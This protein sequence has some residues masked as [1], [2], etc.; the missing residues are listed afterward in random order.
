M[1]PLLSNFSGDVL[2]KYL[3]IAVA[4]LLMAA[5]SAAAQ[6]TPTYSQVSAGLES[7][8]VGTDNR[9]DCW[10]NVPDDKPVGGTWRQVAASQHTCAIRT[11]G[12]VACWGVNNAGEGNP[13]PGKFTEISVGA[14]HTC[15]MR[16]DTALVCWGSQAEGQRN[17]VPGQYV[18][19]SAGAYHTCALRDDSEV[20]CWGVGVS[21]DNSG[22]PGCDQPVCPT[23][24]SLPAGKYKSVSAGSDFQCAIKAD[25]TLACAGR[26][27]GKG[28]LNPP[29]GTFT[30]V[31]AG[32]EGACAIRTD[33]TVACWGD[34][35]AEEE[36]QPP[37]G[38][39]FK[40][41]SHSGGITCGITTA[42]AVRCWGTDQYR[43]NQGPDYTKPVIDRLTAKPTKFRASRGT[44]LWGGSKKYGTV[45]R[46]ELSEYVNYTLVVRKK[47]GAKVTGS[48]T[49]F[50]APSGNTPG[51][52][53]V[54]WTGR[55][56]VGSG[57]RAVKPGSYN[58]FLTPTDRAG[59]V[60]DTKKIA[61]RIIR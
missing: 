31:S 41:V 48:A 43:L 34:N 26:D 36:L 40:Q 11:D 22:L 38:V 18:H 45:L 54:R 51:I 35:P 16:E 8:A 27:A 2:P 53:S 9:L 7:C 37:A 32:D 23:P 46:F 59:N 3:L 50:Q 20:V 25:D 21:R 58:V 5:P 24:W 52:V 28:R 44:N 15:G 56:K 6:T 60:G 12:T 47:S 4:V 39:T 33:G 13:Q 30:Q 29:A 42:S 57:T 19:V 55:L 49:N 10:G 14:Y 61:V 1:V 17:P